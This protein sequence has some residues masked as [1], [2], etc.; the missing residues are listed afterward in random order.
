MVTDRDSFI[1]DL[2]DG[3]NGIAEKAPDIKPIDVGLT[4]KELES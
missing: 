2:V 3:F 1:Y 4:G